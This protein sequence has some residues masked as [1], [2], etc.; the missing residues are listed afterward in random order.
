M[1]TK[2]LT[3]DIVISGAGPAGLA[4]TA[5]LGRAGFKVALLDAEIPAALDYE[6]KPSGRTSALLT[7]S[8]N[9]LKAAGVWPALEDYATALQTMRMVDDET[10]VFLHLGKR[11]P[12]NA[13]VQRSQ[14]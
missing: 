10:I 4:L 5:L 3:A 12:N 13:L 8:V 9:I 6:E 2:D 14:F 7:G 11:V 1:K